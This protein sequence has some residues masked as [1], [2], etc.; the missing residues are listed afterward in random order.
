MTLSQLLQ[1]FLF[2]G[3]SALIGAVFM[4]T[5]QMITR[6]SQEVETT[7][8][9]LAGFCAQA[10]FPAT[11]DP[12]L[13]QIFSE[14]IANLDFPIVITDRANNPRAWRQIDVDPALVPAASIDSLADHLTI[15]PVIRQRI[16]RVRRQVS[17]MDHKNKPI[18]MTAPGSGIP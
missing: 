15:A 11:S 9:V 17:V 16:D 8:R 2:L 7:S 3:G 4:F 6:L 12:Q 1:F 13:R 10:S 5:H 14:V 18:A